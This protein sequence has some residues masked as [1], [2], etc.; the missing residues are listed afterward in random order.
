MYI[1]IYMYWG[2]GV[3]FIYLLLSNRGE[4]WCRCS[5]SPPQLLNTSITSCQVFFL[6]MTL[7]VNYNIFN[8]SFWKSYMLESRILTT[9][10]LLQNHTHTH[11]SLCCSPK[12]R[13]SQG[14][15]LVILIPLKC[16]RERQTSRL[17]LSLKLHFLF[18]HTD[19]V[20]S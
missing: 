5:F 10:C 7:C 9:V 13:K 18:H 8:R 4:E 6:V 12:H 20:Y 17:F 11:T 1:Y 16:G 15:I 3:Y 2:R 19:L 14:H